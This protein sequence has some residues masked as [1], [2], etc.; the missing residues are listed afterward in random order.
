MIL[1]HCFPLLILALISFNSFSQDIDTTAVK[2]EIDSLQITKTLDTI[3]RDSLNI[4]KTLDTIKI[5][6]LNDTLKI[7][8]RLDSL[9]VYKPFDTI[10]RI[11]PVDSLRIELDSLLIP[12]YII[13]YDSILNKYSYVPKYRPVV[14]QFSN[15]TSYVPLP[16]RG[17]FIRSTKRLVI[18]TLQLVNP[19][20]VVTI[21][22][23]KYADDPIW[24]DTKNRFEFDISEA[25]FV[26]WNAG[27][28]NSISGL[29]KLSLYRNYEK[30]YVLWK[31]EILVR[32]GLNSQQDQELRKTDDKIQ[33]NSTFG[34]RKDTLSNWYYSVK[35]SF[36]TQFT[37]GYSYPDTATPI[38]R[39]FAPAYL[40]LGAGT[41]YELTKKRFF[42]YMSPI[43]IKS[44]LVLDETLSNEGVFGVTPGKKSRNEFGALIQGSWNTEIVKNIV[45]KNK[46][47]LYSDY[48]NDF[49]NIDVNWDLTLLFTINKYFQAN[50]GAYFIYDND[51]KY[52]EDVNND[53]VLETFGPRLQLK[54]LLGIGVAFTF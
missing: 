15:D 8:S 48:L 31:N 37:E 10:A 46:W 51:I 52:K 22:T 18:D 11:S 16:K 1:K 42:L 50:I 43:T 26:N 9:G 40:F 25:A 5:E 54:Q 14:K 49:G 17:E 23:T 29:A 13:R 35:F 2:N 44:T 20:K 3:K 28:N 53:G 45:M 19:I 12:F 21:D 6:I 47:S 30:L 7:R 4:A 34:Y 36:N 38:S 39:F 27:G 32:Y 41:Q 24:W 33:I